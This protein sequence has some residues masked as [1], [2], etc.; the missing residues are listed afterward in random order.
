M[1]ADPRQQFEAA[2]AQR[3]AWVMDYLAQDERKSLF[4][5]QDIH[6]AVYTYIKAGGKALRPCLLLLACGAVGGDE[7]SALAA[8]LAVELFHTWTMVHDDIMDRDDLR[9]GHPTVHED[10]R[11]RAEDRLGYDEDEAKHYGLSIGIMTAEVQHGWAIS[12]MAELYDSARNNEHVVLKLIRELET[13]ILLALVGGQTLDI[14]YSKVPI[15][16]LKE[17]DILD[18]LWRKTGALIQYSGMAGAMIGLNTADTSHPLVKAVATF[19]SECGVA[20]QLKDD[21]LGVVGDERKLGKPVGSDIREGKR[22]IILT[23]AFAHAS[24]SERA[25]L[26][27]VVGNQ[28][29]TESDVEEVRGILQS[30]GGVRYTEDMATRRI[31]NAMGNLESLPPSI[32]KDLLSSW[33]DYLVGRTF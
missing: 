33:A 32:Q 3:K 8:A 27:G 10:F 17:E 15:D 4:V 30:L 11:R 5:P 25:F 21:V 24:E 29:A 26:L 18:V 14:Q 23:H 7:R 1:T 13:D 28:A 16:S 19:T 20:F 6:D 22:T 2:L 31:E 9:R 12:L